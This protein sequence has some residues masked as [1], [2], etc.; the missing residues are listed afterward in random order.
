[1]TV[2]N[3]VD[4]D[5]SENGDLD[6]EEKDPYFDA[7]NLWVSTLISLLSCSVSIW[8][9]YFGIFNSFSTGLGLTTEQQVSYSNKIIQNIRGGGGGGLMYL[10][11]SD[12][13]DHTCILQFN[14][15]QS[16][17]SIQLTV[18]V[19]HLFCPK[20]YAFINMGNMYC[21]FVVVWNNEERDPQSEHING[22]GGRR[23]HLYPI[24]P[25]GICPL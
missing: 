10:C 9:I 22:G 2:E 24:L 25:S 1:M 14:C 16:V 8:T 11:Y 20:I 21:F 19:F 4:K 6:S 12:I 3:N 17:K 18:H 7:L 13:Y 5:T 15:I 23:R